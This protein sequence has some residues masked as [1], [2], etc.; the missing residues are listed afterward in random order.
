MVGNGTPLLW[1]RLQILTGERPPAATLLGFP[2][3][4]FLATS[5]RPCPLPAG[6]RRLLPQAKRRR[7]TLRYRSDRSRE[8]PSRSRG[9]NCTAHGGGNSSTIVSP[10]LSKSATGGLLASGQSDDSSDSA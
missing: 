6:L 8:G 1:E 2:G 3:L 5:S 10:A 9:T 7:S 4:S